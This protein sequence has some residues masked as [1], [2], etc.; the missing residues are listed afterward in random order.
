MSPW[1]APCASLSGERRKDG[2]GFVRQGGARATVPARKE[3]RGGSGMGTRAKIESRQRCQEKEGHTVQGSETNTAPCRGHASVTHVGPTTDGFRRTQ[4]DGDPAN[5]ERSPNIGATSHLC[6]N[7]SRL[8]LFPI[9]LL[10]LLFSFG[11][12][13]APAFRVD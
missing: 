11:I 3:T 12:Q 13:L 10:F 4:S 1:C 6:S 9:A 8:L 7:Y 2:M 5:V